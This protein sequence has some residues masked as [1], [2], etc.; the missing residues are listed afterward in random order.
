MNKSWQISRRHMLRGIGA[1]LALPQLEIMA[2]GSADKAETG[3]SLG[4][5][6]M[7]FLSF[8]IPNGVMPAAWDVKGEGTDYKMSPIIKPL[9]SIREDVAILSGLNNPSAGHVG[10]TSSFL[11]GV[12]LKKGKS[13]ESLDMRIARHIGQNTQFSSLVLG[14]E[15]PRQGKTGG[16]AISVASSVS[17]SSPT[18]RVSPEINPQS[19]FDRL[20]R[21]ASGADAVKDAKLKKS[22]ID[23]VLE[24]AKN[25]QRKASY[26]DKQKIEEYLEGV[27]SVEKQITKT[28][29]PIEADWTPPTKPDEKDFVRPLAGIPRDRGEHLK[30]MMDIMVLALWTDSTRVCTLMAA[31]GFSRQNFSFLD[32]V[33]GDHHSIS[34]HKGIKSKTDQYTRVS[35]WYVEQFEYLCQRLKQIDE[36]GSSVFDNSVMMFGSGMKDGNGHIRSNLPILLAGK[37]QGKLNMGSHIKLPKQ[38]IGNLHLTLAQKFGIEDEDFNNTRSRVITELG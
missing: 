21:A 28:I 8:F 12:N 7:R 6:P 4:P 9:D 33:K 3:A 27:R 5:A 35:Q 16:E 2:Q 34:H 18:T 23:L 17:W 26:L 30:L 24:D 32:G 13:G 19:A 37:A 36:G 38:N 15:P 20:F 22:V 10:M 14:T 25:L 11:T 31:H 1:M 29:N